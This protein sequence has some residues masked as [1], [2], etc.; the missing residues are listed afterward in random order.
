MFTTD[1]NVLINSLKQTRTI[2]CA[3]NTA[4]KI[5][6]DEE[7]LI[8]SNIDSFSNDV[9]RVTNFGTSFYTVLS[10]MTGEKEIETIKYRIMCTQLIQQDAI[11]ASGLRW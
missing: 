7:D 4:E 10:G 5:V 11:H 6:P 8:K 1:N 9:G 2:V 3:Q